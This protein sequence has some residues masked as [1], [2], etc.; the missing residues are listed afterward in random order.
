MLKNLVY[1]VFLGLLLAGC[2]KKSDVVTSVDERQA[3]EIVVYLASKGITATK[4]LQPTSTTA[5][6]T[7]TTSLF[8]IQVEGSRQLEAMA[9]LN[10]VGLP[11]RIGQSLLDL[12]SDTGLMTSDKT[13]TIR[14]Q[15][16]LELDLANM[17]RQIDGVIDCVVKLSIPVQSAIGEEQT[18]KPSSA[19]YVKHEGV[20]DDPNSHLVTKIKRLVSSAYPDLDYNNVTVV[21]D[22]SR[23][24]DVSLPQNP[25][26]IYSDGPE[27]VTLWSVTME[28]HSVGQFRALFFF[29]SFLILAFALLT[30]FL[31]WKFYPMLS[32]RGLKTLLSLK[33]ITF[34]EQPVAP[35]KEKSEEGVE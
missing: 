22:K 20:M 24:T 16:G 12:F 3:N 35:K 13:E 19:V 25:D 14:Y 34:E 33:P 30:A 28:K 6:A 18:Q 5:G 15:G 11:R 4:M 31:V 32:S 2:V 17:I 9:I 7:Q 29:F 27:L 10:R 1:F 21:S 23:F 8:N 26:L